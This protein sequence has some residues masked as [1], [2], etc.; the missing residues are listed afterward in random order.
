MAD[1]AVRTKRGQS[2]AP[3]INMGIGTRPLVNRIKL[4]E[5]LCE[6]D[7]KL[8]LLDILMKNYAQ[9]DPRFEPYLEQWGW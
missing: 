8:D 6:A 5:V 2:E 3:S 9:N 7:N 4:F 1:E